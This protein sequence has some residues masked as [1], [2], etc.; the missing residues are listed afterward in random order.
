MRVIQA[1]G[2]SRLCRYAHAILSASPLVSTKPKNRTSKLRR[3]T[4]L[5]NFISVKLLHRIVVTKNELFLFGK[6]EDTN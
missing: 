3:L 5:G 4:N 6:G 2:S 1:G